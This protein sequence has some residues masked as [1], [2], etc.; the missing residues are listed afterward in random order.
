[1]KSPFHIILLALITCVSFSINAQNVSKANK[2]YNRLGYQ[3]A[4]PHYGDSEDLSTED[5]IK[6]A[7]AFRLTGQ[8]EETEM[9]LRKVTN[10]NIDPIHTLHLAQAL[11]MNNK[12]DE[13]LNYFA[14][15]NT[16]VKND[17]SDARA[18]NYISFIN[19][20]QFDKHQNVEINN[21][22]KVNTD[23]Y[24]FSPFLTENGILFVSSR[25]HAFSLMPQ[26]RIYG[27]KKTTTNYTSVQLMKMDLSMILHYFRQ[28]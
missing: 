4:I 7:S 20:D 9:L 18:N 11:L 27:Q 10:E 5:I 19:S 15:Y 2:L 17:D 16:L 28:N 12:V 24:E 3:V 14:K 22:D 1:M 13:S 26:Q 8:S 6:L 21:S 25:P 23:N